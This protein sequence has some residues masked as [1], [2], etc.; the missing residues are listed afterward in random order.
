MS[1]KLVL[2]ESINWAYL[3]SVEVLRVI[4]PRRQMEEIREMVSDWVADGEELTQIEVSLPLILAD[5]ARIILHLD[6]EQTAQALGAEMY[7]AVLVLES[8]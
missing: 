8:R 3:P 7:S 5:F 1:N 2:R 4:D 6:E